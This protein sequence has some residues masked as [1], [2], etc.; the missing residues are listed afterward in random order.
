M[1]YNQWVSGRQI[2]PALPRPLE[3]F[4]AGA[5][6]PLNP[7]VPMPID[8]PRQE[9]GRPDP[10][11]WQ[12]PVGWN[13]PVGVPGTEGIKL[14]SFQALRRYADV[15]SVVR[16]M[17]DIRK[18]E[19]A[20]MNWDIGPTADSQ[21]KAKTDKGYQKDLKERGGQLVKWF[22]RVDSNYY[23]FQQWFGALLEEVFVV[24]ALALHP[25]PPRI[26]GKGLFGGNLAE[27]ELLNGDTIR[28]LVDLR[29]AMPRPPAPAYQQFLWGV[30]RADMMAI[31]G[32]EDIDEMEVRLTEAGID[33][34]AAPEKEFAADQLLY[35][36]Y[37]RRTWTP[38]GFSPIEQAIM[39]IS[40]GLQ[41][42]S[43]LLDYFTEGTIPGVYV[44]AG[45][46]FV[47]PAQQRQL[48]DSLN[49]LAGDAAWKHRVI[50]LPPGS[51]TD[52]QKDLAWQRDVD[53]T[54]VEMVQMVLRIQPH[55]IG[56]I[57]GGR[58]SG[59]GGKGMT[60]EMH[61]AT[62]ET[63]TEPLRNWTKATIF[64]W[65]IQH[66]FEQEDLEWKWVDFEDEE[67]EQQR[68]DAEKSDI[69]TGLR[70]I[71]EIRID[72]GLDPWGTDY[73]SHPFLVGGPSGLIPLDP[74]VPPPA[75]PAPAGPEGLGGAG[76]TGA[77]GGTA[78]SALSASLKPE[79]GKNPEKPKNNP[80]A[81]LLGDKKKD[82]RK[83]RNELVDRFK[84]NLK[85][86]QRMHNANNSF[87]G[88]GD[89][90]KVAALGGFSVE[91]LMALPFSD[92]VR[93]LHIKGKVKYKGDLTDIVH[94]YLLRSYPA[95][96]VEWVEDPKGSWDFDRHVKLS[97]IN[98]AR[99]PGGRNPEKVK[100]ISKTLGNG[101]SMDPIV[102]VDAG[103]PH[104]YDIADG[105]HRT[106]GAE[107]AGWTDV[108]AFIG[109]GFGDHGM[110]DVQMQDDSASKKPQKMAELSA[111]RAYLRHGKPATQFKSD[112]LGR[113]EV[114][115]IADDVIG[116]GAT[117]AFRLAR[118]RVNKAEIRARNEEITLADFL[119]ASKVAKRVPLDETE[120]AYLWKAGNPQALR[121]WFNAGAD[122]QID[123]GEDGD[124]MQCVNVAADH[125]SEEDAKGF[126]NLRHTDATGGPPGTEKNFSL[127]APV[128]TGLVPYDLAGQT[129]S[130]P[131]NVC[132]TCGRAL[133]ANGA[134]PMGH[135]FTG[136]FNPHHDERG[137]FSDADSAGGASPYQVGDRVRVTSG[138]HAGHEGHI[139]A[140]MNSRGERDANGRYHSVLFTGRG[141]LRS[142]AG[143]YHHSAL[144]PADVRTTG[145]LAFRAGRAAFPSVSS[146]STKEDDPTLGLLAAVEAELARRGVLGDSA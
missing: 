22:K 53:Q 55:E 30:P 123:W 14:A 5:F 143:L 59:L 142:E 42:Q 139:T 141:G 69:Q 46:Q 83:A 80:A 103:N 13:L 111:L 112:V 1:Q 85:D 126:C 8:E 102:L 90:N 96:D 37:T 101:A 6:G 66:V 95:K 29:G 21:T 76:P 61:E 40:I 62:T 31:L 74:T 7:L 20:G 97:D 70:S 117:E 131:A 17:L 81:A 84:D 33:T 44:I 144:E 92:E 138:L 124:F 39:P 3:D 114:R 91:D 145:A 48:Q 130:S 41:R 63:R 77:A 35:L 129:V 98:M 25:L 9:S 113:D 110:W 49:A 127:S 67:D 104:G 36:P 87:G 19:M 73:T 2:G 51:K 99:R 122:G 125:M 68:A 75:A 78:A 134:C 54:V 107:D 50:V 88:G 106:L 26:K 118:E 108:P 116:Y 105:W 45:D 4:I 100:A 137:R 89:K 12:Y 38:Y 136:K 15:Y 23:G 140:T 93:D 57:P 10:R 146:W 79:P 121:D 71:D 135:E 18:D 34:E 27:L 60:Q 47:T 82:R 24:D 120:T 56:M 32:E 52:P 11:R 86:A 109:K 115:C 128:A 72:N 65:V 64:D 94:E 28:P 43:F 133:D 58:S 16:A 119:V 132:P